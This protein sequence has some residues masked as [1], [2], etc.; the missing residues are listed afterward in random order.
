MG[1]STLISTCDIRLFLHQI[2]NLNKFFNGNVF[3][4]VKCVSS[5]GSVA[6]K[7]FRWN[8]RS[9]KVTSEN[10]PSRSCCYNFTKFL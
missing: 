10:Q 5:L 8:C 1:S 3:T 4:A 6:A 9:K 2:D 7:I